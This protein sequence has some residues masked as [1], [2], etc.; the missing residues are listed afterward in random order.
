MKAKLRQKKLKSGNISLYIDYY[1]PVWNPA[2]KSYTRRE[3][4]NLILFGNPQ[5]N[6]E[7]QQNALN[8]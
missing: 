4:L 7:K 5:T 8:T 3:F 1:P 2:R 6:F